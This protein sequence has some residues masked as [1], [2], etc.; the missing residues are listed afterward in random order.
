MIQP[1]NPDRLL[2]HK[3]IH[4]MSTPIVIIETRSGQLEALYSN[5]D[6][7]F[8]VVDR[9]EQDKSTASGPFS[10][11]REKQDL[12]QIAQELCIPVGLLSIQADTPYF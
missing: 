5:T 9:D 1:V 12:C 2:N 3:T 10:P 4:T 7:R 8:I 11:T 6:I